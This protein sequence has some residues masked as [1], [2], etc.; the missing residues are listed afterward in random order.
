MNK[1][2]SVV[3]PVYKVE[4]Y[5]RQCLGSL[6]LPDEAL[7][8]KMEVLVVNDGTPDRSAII[9]KEYEAKYPDVFHVIDKENG[10]HGPAFNVG[11]AQASGKY[12]RFLD[13]DDWFDTKNLAKLLNVL[14]NTDVDMFLTPFLYY[15][16]QTKDYKK[17]PIVDI[18]FNKVLNLNSVDLV[19]THN[20]NGMTLFH[21][22][23]YRTEVL[24]KHV[25]LFVEHVFYDDNILR[26][27]PITLFNSFMA[28]NLPVYNYRIDRP[29]QTATSA[30][31]KSHA[32]DL[33]HVI[34]NIADFIN[35]NPL[36]EGYKKE[37][38]RYTMK[39]LM[40]IAFGRLF[41]QNYDKSKEELNEFKKLMKKAK[42]MYEEPS[43]LRML[44]LLPYPIF[45]V[46]YRV[47]NRITK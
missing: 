31:Q 33:V 24:Q 46:F 13:S 19:H 12:L 8:D 21:E 38:V 18:E 29:G 32:K 43:Q 41:S 28:I 35:S 23:T 26:I 20:W 4:K 37:Y 30:N 14:I 42:G 11:L 7:M 17:E 22:A 44:E 1:L 6:I 47:K 45:Y 36:E 27:A 3:I 15:S 16:E 9:A 25:P 10:G 34:D 39:D 40:T 2:L 5:I